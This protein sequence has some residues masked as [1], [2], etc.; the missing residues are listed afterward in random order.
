MSGTVDPIDADRRAAGRPH[1]GSGPP[2][3]RR[4]RARLTFSPK[5][6]IPLTMLCRDRC[7]YCTFAKPPA[8][9]DAP[10]LELDEVLAIARRGADARLPRGAVHP[11]RGP[12]GPLPRR[13]GAGSPRTATRRP[14]TTSSPPPR[15]CSPR[16]GCSP[17][18]TPG[19]RRRPSSTA[20]RAVSPVAG[21]DDRDAGRPARRARAARTP[22]RP[23]RP[24]PAAWPRSKRPGAAAIPFTTGI[25][26]G[27]GETRAERL[28]ALLAIRDVAR[29]ATGTCRK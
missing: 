9:L 12:R 4:P 1:G 17:T 5:V 11:R 13:R 15:R 6:F 21:D 28:D 16:P 2:P 19:A 8:H 29:R 10:Y 18:P 22:A 25:L 14:S 24:R 20:L 27:I 23:T 7:G 3:R 26:V